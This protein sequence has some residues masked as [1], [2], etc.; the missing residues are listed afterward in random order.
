VFNLT[1][2]LHLLIYF[3]YPLSFVQNIDTLDLL[4]S[5][6]YAL[7]FVNTDEFIESFNRNNRTYIWFNCLSDV[8]TKHENVCF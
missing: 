5:I 3:G 4:N 8:R 1:D 2:T 6:K 7:S